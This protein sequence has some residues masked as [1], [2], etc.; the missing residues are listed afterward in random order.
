MLIA[1]FPVVIV[2]PVGTWFGLRS[3]ADGKGPGLSLPI[4]GGRKADIPLERTAG[5]LIADLVV[6][7]RLS[8]VVDASEFSEGDKIRF[9]TDFAERLYRKN[10]EPVHLV[11]EEADDYIPQRP[12]RDQAR[13]LRAFE[14]IVRRGRARGLGI[15]LV[16]QRS[17]AVN[18]SVLTQVETLIVHRTTSPQDRQAVKGWI[19]YHGQSP[20]LLASLPGL[21]D[22]EAWIWSPHWLGKLVRVQVHRRATFDSAATPKHSKGHRPAATL[23]DVDLVAIQ[24]RMAATIE[25]AK[26]ED[27]RELRREI[28]RLKAEVAAKAEKTPA[29]ANKPPTIVEKRLLKAGDISRLEKSIERVAAISDRVN[30][31]LRVVVAEVGNLA[32]ILRVAKAP[33]VVQ[34]AVVGRPSIPVPRPPVRR[35]VPTDGEPVTGPE[36]RI[37]DAIAWIESLG[38]SDADQA[39][40]AF[41]AGYTV[42]GGAFNNPRGKLHTRGLIEYRGGRLGLTE[43]GR[44]VSRAPVKLLSTEE[45]HAAV[46]ERLPGPEGKILRVLLEV[47][48][49]AV[50]HSE[51]AARAGYSDGGGAFNNP[52]GRLR[53]LGLID[54]PSRGMAVAKPLLF[55]ER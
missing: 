21:K 8:C 34:T 45:L 6:D 24:Q 17:A 26:Q 23:V 50:S 22:G 29:I 12:F 41:L 10:Q 13:C 35:P 27:P 47:Y 5:V 48:P 38:Q 30:N 55:L 52:R 20:E 46:L 44:L 15:T 1:K 36:Q 40:A 3:S 51:L 9:L 19:E 11:L 16:T 25:R 33:T 31:G 28:A 42:G 4:F 43:A 18:K 14:N 32:T 54:Y 2:D 37:L 7:N 53:S 39:A 49:K